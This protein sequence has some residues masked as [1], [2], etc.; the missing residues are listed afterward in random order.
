MSV[1]A[2]D[3][4]YMQAFN[5]A[6]EERNF[7]IL[8]LLIRLTQ[9]MVEGELLQLTC[10]RKLDLTEDEYFELTYRKTA[11]LF[12]ACTRLGA[13][14]G[15]RSEDE[16]SRLGSYGVNLGIAFQLIDDVLDFTSTEQ[17]L[18]KPIGSDLRE[19]KLTL[20]LIYLLQQCRPEERT[21]VARVLTDNE[22]KTVKF[23]EVHDLIFRYGT[24]DAARQKALEF[25]ERAKQDLE[26]F[27]DSPYKDA[28]RVVPDFVLDRES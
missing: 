14:L 24:L 2:G 9:V 13:I 18:G 22:F 11:C 5:S 25:V 4:L 1:L 7:K 8:D 19:G 20:P 6:L 3:W 12:S 16:E 23:N 27:P 15:R 26:L 21:L 10:L 28:L 17:V